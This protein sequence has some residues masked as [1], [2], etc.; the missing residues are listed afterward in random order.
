MRSHLNL[1]FTRFL[2]AV[3][4]ANFLTLA[5]MNFFE[6]PVYTTVLV[7]LGATVFGIQLTCQLHIRPRRA[8]LD[9][10]SIAIAVAMLILLT[11]P[12][13]V[14]ALQWLPATEVRVVG[15]DYAHLAELASLTLSNHY[16]LRHPSNGEYL[17][18]FYYAAFYPLAVLKL[19]V[20]LFTLKDV[21]IVGNFFYHFLILASLVEIGHL[22]FARAMQVRW[23]VF[24]CTFFAGLDWLVRFFRASI[25]SNVVGAAILCRQCDPA[26]D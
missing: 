7:W 20:P 1:P 6:L 26:C 25:E 13:L 23:F 11:I 5:V 19:A 9:R 17:L 15:D 10:V 22:F 4:I 24:L 16:P 8:R 3:I 18:S 14:Y 2:S 12:R 21:L